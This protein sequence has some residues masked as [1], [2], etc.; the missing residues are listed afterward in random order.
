MDQQVTGSFTKLGEVT[1]LDR[2]TVKKLLA[3]F[4]PISGNDKNDT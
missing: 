4:K 3:D 1:G 2:R